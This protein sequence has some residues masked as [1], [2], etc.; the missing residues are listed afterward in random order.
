MIKGFLLHDKALNELKQKKFFKAFLD[1]LHS[2]F[3]SKYQIKEIINLIK[4]EMIK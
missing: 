1:I 2:L 3:L 4:Y